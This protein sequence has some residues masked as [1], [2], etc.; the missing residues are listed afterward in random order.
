MG[1]FYN[2]GKMGHGNGGCEGGTIKDAVHDFW[3]ASLTFPDKR[4]V[5]DSTHSFREIIRK[6]HKTY[7]PRTHTETQTPMAIS[8]NKGKHPPPPPLALPSFTLDVT[9]EQGKL[10]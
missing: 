8:F 9:G 3:L 5:G 2:P 7:S 6:T 1:K 10:L 4:R